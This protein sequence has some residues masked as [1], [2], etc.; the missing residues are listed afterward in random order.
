MVIGQIW[1]YNFRWRANEIGTASHSAEKKNRPREGGDGFLIGGFAQKMF[2]LRSK[3]T[4]LF[5]AKSTG[6][7]G[8]NPAQRFR[9]HLWRGNRKRAKIP[10]LKPP[11]FLPACFNARRAGAAAALEKEKRIVALDPPNPFAGDIKELPK[12]L[13]LKIKIF[14]IILI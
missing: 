13:L 9:P 8:L 10:S 5:L 6:F 7:C 1:I 2:E 12:F 3:N 14:G 4:E 11:S